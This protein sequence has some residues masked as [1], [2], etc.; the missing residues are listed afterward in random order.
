MTVQ[1]VQQQKGADLGEVRELEGVALHS[2]GHIG[3]IHVIAIHGTMLCLL[4]QLRAILS[5]HTA[6]RVLVGYG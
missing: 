6:Q 2:L 1:L 3:D 4:L 5:N